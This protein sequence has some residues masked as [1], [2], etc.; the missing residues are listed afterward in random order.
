MRKAEASAEL[1]GAADG[2]E[3]DE[4]DEDDDDEEDEED[5]DDEE[6]D[7]DEDDDEDEVVELIGDAITGDGRDDACVTE[8]APSHL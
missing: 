4:A 7:E 3:D 6:D 8:T 1:L 2:G 5:D